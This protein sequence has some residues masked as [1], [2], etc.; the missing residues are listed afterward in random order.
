MKHNVN[1]S[2]LLPVYNEKENLELLIPELVKV[3]EEVCNNYEIIIID[4]SSNDETAKLME[5]YIE[6]FTNVKYVV[7]VINRSLPL[8]IYNSRKRLIQYTTFS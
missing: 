4:D 3:C 5:S 6:L 8:S 2:I 1:L 7:R